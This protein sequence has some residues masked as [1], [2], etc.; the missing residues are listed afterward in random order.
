MNKCID[1]SIRNNQYQCSK[2]NKL[3]VLFILENRDAKDFDQKRL[4]KFDLSTNKI[5][6]TIKELKDSN[7]EFSCSRDEPYFENLLLKSLNY[8]MN[9]IEL[10]SRKSGKLKSVLDGG[11]LAAVV[12][13]DLKLD[14]AYLPFIKVAPVNKYAYQLEIIKI[15]SF[16]ILT[17]IFVILMI[18]LI[19]VLYIYYKGKND[20][21]KLNLIYI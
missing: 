12:P 16:I 11:I 5:Q 19:C 8:N 17:P 18:I 2:C 4:F 7:A 21:R 15:E 20:L 13:E 6:T 1:E 9:Q 14:I 10:M 3:V